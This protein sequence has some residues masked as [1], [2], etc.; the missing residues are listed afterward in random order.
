MEEVTAQNRKVVL[1]SFVGKGNE[2]TLEHFE[3]LDEET[4]DLKDGEV[5]LQTLYLSVDPYMRGRMNDTKSYI[6]PFK[7]GQ[8]LEGSGV[9]KVIETKNDNYKVGDVLTSQKHLVWPWISYPVFDDEFASKFTGANTVPEHLLSATVG[10]LGMPGLTAYFGVKERGRPKD[11]ETIV[12]S[13]GAGACGSVAGQ[14]A[15]I[16]GCSNVVGIARN[17]EKVDYM[18]ND[19]GFSS[20]IIYDGKTREQLSADIK[21]A[22][23]NGV[24]IYYDNVGGEISEAVLENMNEN[25]RVPVCGQISQYNKDEMSPIPDLLQADLDAKNV[26]RGWFMVMQFKDKFEEGWKE[27]FGWVE[28]GKMKLRETVVE[29]LENLP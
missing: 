14:V 24:D 16:L 26:E 4:V 21:A 18:V 2:P 7:V 27:M 1:K 10:F 19:L 20:G 25:G 23:P 8:P 22:C 29:G 17:Q 5:R 11:G 3:V 12:I 13:G 9:G 6:P 15:R 28:D